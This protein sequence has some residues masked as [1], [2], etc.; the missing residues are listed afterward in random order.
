MPAA[1]SSRQGQGFSDRVG[2]HTWPGEP[3]C[4][5]RVWRTCMPCRSRCQRR[6]VSLFSLPVSTAWLCG[7][8]PTHARLPGASPPNGWTWASTLA[9]GKRASTASRLVPAGMS[10]MCTC[11][12]TREACSPGRRQPG[13]A[14]TDPAPLCRDVLPGRARDAGLMP[15]G[16]L[17]KTGCEA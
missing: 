14:H 6:T 1:V 17:P 7:V 10:R 15:G 9:C 2:P 4:R 12:R 8:A 13:A 3:G 11:S 16:L 5:L